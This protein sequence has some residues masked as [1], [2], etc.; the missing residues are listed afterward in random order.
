MPLLSHIIVKGGV[1]SLL[2]W[3]IVISYSCTY[4]MS[5][6]FASGHD[7][8]QLFLA[9]ES[10][11]SK[12]KYTKARVFYDRAADL[13][14][15]ES[16]FRSAI[17]HKEGVGGKGEKRK[18]YRLMLF[19]ASTEIPIVRDEVDLALKEIIVN[20][21]F[22]VARMI[23]GGF[24]V[25]SSLKKAMPWYEQA[26]ER[27]HYMAK[28]RMGCLHMQGING[29]QDFTKAQDLFT[30]I[31]EHIAQSKLAKFFLAKMAYDGC[32]GIPDYGLAAKYILTEGVLD[33]HS[34]ARILLAKMHLYGEGVELNRETA[35]D[36]LVYSAE[37]GSAFAQRMLDKV[38]DCSEEY[39][40]P[41]VKVRSFA[42]IPVLGCVAGWLR[43][44]DVHNGYQLLDTSPY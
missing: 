22:L 15:V 29:K 17:M 10:M 33:A 39:A 42:S 14:H 1:M 20:A 30:S 37:Q 38:L 11:R 35:V 41:E 32:F 12:S 8:E 21:Q 31:P 19:V 5:L 7:A 28:I 4:F 2:K 24:G 18:A 13:G 40:V 9:G 25:R 6:G 26:V 3:I 36:L 16:S 43:R 23:E 34:G 44:G 27:G